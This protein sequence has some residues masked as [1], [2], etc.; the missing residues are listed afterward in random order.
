MRPRL[1]L[2][3]QIL[4]LQVLI[5]LVT[6][7]VSA[8][9]GVQQMRSQLTRQEGAKALAVAEA[10]ASLPSVRAAFD[11]PDPSEVLQPLAASVQ[12]S[13][14]VTFVVLAD[15]DQVRLAHPDVAE[16]GRRL[17]T[18]AADALAGQHVVT[19]ERG[20][21]GRSVR[22]KVPVLD[23]AGQVVGVVSVGSLEARIGEQWRGALPRLLVLLLLALA[24]GA[25]GSWLLARRLKR[26]T[27]GLEPAEI[28]RLLEQRE[29]TL[30]GVREGLLVLDGGGR[31]TLVNDEAVRLLHIPP[32]SAGRRVADLDLTPRLRDVLSGS[33]DGEDEIVLRAG[34]VLVLNRKPLDVRGRGIGAVVTLR[35]RTELEDL[36]R[37]LGG[38]RS[39]TDA[40][41]AQAHEFANRMHTVAGLL[42]LGEHDEA[43]TFIERVSAVRDELA[44]QLTRSVR[45]PAVAA[46]L[47]AKTAYAAEHDVELRL[48]DDSALPPASGA[49]VEAL[50]TVVGNLVDNAVEALRGAPGWVQV[51]LVAGSDGVQIEVRDSG[52]GIE[53]ALAEEVF[54]HGFT[55]KIAES[56]GS[57]GLGLA[58]TRQA[59]VTRGGWVDVRNEGGAVFTAFLPYDAVAAAR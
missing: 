57:R 15:R 21:L 39:V 16:I 51:R 35:D 54:R 56:A 37:E 7:A 42:E 8:L 11:D 52:P 46:L 13:S 50:V 45:E 44:G 27:F 9:V 2:A 33:T 32:D 49:D 20:T 14:G 40:L 17:S 26:Q 4:A 48:A 36:T 53:P 24:V 31:I 10:V 30:H 1:S 41:R 12:R 38:A 28:G 22:A 25:F 47:L 34:R 55:T 19:T 29:A 43:L 3:T 18:D 23:P 59:C 5:V 58:L 6:V